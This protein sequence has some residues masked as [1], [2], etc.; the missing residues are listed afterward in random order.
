M[1]SETLMFSYCSILITYACIRAN[2]LWIT[3][4]IFSGADVATIIMSR[5]LNALPKDKS[6]SHSNLIFMKS[7]LY[8]M[9]HYHLL[10]QFA[11]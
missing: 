6:S 3:F 10:L 11:L 9:V 8:P 2:K 1:P 4:A 5:I 7:F